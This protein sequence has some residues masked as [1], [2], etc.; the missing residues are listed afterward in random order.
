M[1]SSMLQLPVAV[2][3]VP[4]PQAINS[5]ATR[6]LRRHIQHRPPSGQNVS[7]E[8]FKKW[9][10]T[11]LWRFP[12]LQHLNFHDN[13]PL[14]HYV[15]AEA[16]EEQ[17]SRRLGTVGSRIIAEVFFGLLLS[18]PTSYWA[19]DRSWKPVLPAGRNPNYRPP[20]GRVPFTM[21]DLLTFARVA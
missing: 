13:T 12:S 10:K 17:D 1:S 21:T 11:K 5:L 18:D 16:F 9:P 7:R 2:G 3:T 20:G 4:D 15:L 6:N 14:W 8:I 19:S